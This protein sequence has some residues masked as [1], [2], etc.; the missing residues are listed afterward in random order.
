MLKRFSPLHTLRSTGE[1]HTKLRVNGKPSLQCYY[2]KAIKPA[3]LRRRIY[4]DIKVANSDIVL[5]HYLQDAN[6]DEELRSASTMEVDGDG[7]DETHTQG[8]P[9]PSKKRRTE[10]AIDKDAA[11]TLTLIQSGDQH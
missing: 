9:R 2:C 4:R 10:A 5:L 7:G 6:A 11:E 3:G 8:S 1:S